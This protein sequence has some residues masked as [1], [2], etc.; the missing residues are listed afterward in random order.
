MLSFSSGLAASLVF[1]SL[2]GS[3][4]A[5]PLTEKLRGLSPLARDF[6]KR[7]TPVAPYFVAYNDEWLNPLPTAADLEVSK[8]STFPR[9]LR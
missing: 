5:V 8:K 2:F 3:L 6:L 4:Q 1:V 7:S 9:R